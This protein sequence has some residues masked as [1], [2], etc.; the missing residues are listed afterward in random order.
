M[1]KNSF[2][3]CT[4]F[5][6]FTVFLYRYNVYTY[7]AYA[8]YQKWYFHNINNNRQHLARYKI[9]QFNIAST[10]SIFLETS[11]FLMFFA[12]VNLEQ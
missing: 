7:Y 1:F 2:L 8:Y 10:T 11:T 3:N 4:C 9:R 6:L 12:I 5:S